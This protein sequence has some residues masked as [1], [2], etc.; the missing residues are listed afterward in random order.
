MELNKN[1]LLNK[2]KSLEKFKDQKWMSE[3]AIKADC[4]Y[5]ELPL[6]SALALI[7]ELIL[8][9]ERNKFRSQ[10]EMCFSL[11]VQVE[12]LRQ[13]LLYFCE[14]SESEK[15]IKGTNLNQ[16]DPIHTPPKH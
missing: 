14:D 16:Q 12:Q 6:K 8:Y 1:E 13:L 5:K 11:K 10:W 2:F 7:D 15:T 4:N 3:E 9:I